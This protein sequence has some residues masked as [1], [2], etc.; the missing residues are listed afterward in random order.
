MG[1]GAPTG[2]SMY[3]STAGMPGAMSNAMV[4]TGGGAPSFFG[5]QAELIAKQQQEEA[6]RAR[7][8]AVRSQIADRLRKKEELIQRIRTVQQQ[9]LEIARN[10]SIQ[11]QTIERTKKSTS[12]F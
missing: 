7:T 8:L 3:G 5:Q 9:N 4:T 11:Q 12:Q 1:G 6:Q 2:P 10:L